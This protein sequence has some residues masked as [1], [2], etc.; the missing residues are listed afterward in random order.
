[1]TSR[2]DLPF[3]A[4]KQVRLSANHLVLSAVLA[5]AAAL[6]SHAHAGAQELEGL[7]AI[8]AEEVLD[9]WAMALGGRERLGGI[10]SLY[11]RARYE[12]TAGSGIVEEWSTAAGQR[13]QASDLTTGLE[14]TIFDVSRG[15][16]SSMN[17]IARELSPDERRAQLTAAYLA[18][19]SA[20]VSGRLAGKAE[21]AGQD[22]ARKNHLV[23]L[24]PEGGVPTLIAIDKETHLPSWNQQILTTAVLTIVFEGWREVSGIMVPARLRL[25]TDGGYA[26]TETL[27]EALANPTVED[28]LFERPPDRTGDLLFEGERRTATIPV[29]AIGGHLFL[30][31]RIGDS[32]P[33]WLTL[34]SGASGSILDADLA[35]SLG[36]QTTGRPQITGSGGAVEGA[37]AR[38]VTV[39][40]AGVRLADQTFLTMPLD[41]LS[42]PTGRRTA[43]ILGYN[44]FSRLTVEIDY[45]A[46]EIRLHDPSTFVYEG[47]GESLPLTIHDDQPYIRAR[48]GL[49]ERGE[50]EGEFVVDT[51]SASTLMIA[52]DFARSHRLL[53]SVG[54]TLVAS[55]R[56]V[57]GDISLTVGRLAA[58]KIGPFTLTQPVV[59]F[60]AGVITARGKAGNIGAGALRR[61]LVVFDY[62]RQ[63]LI[64]EP[65]SVYDEPDEY[66]M[67]GLSLMA[68]GTELDV[69]RVERVREGAPGEEA[70]VR[71]EDVLRSV[72]SRPAREIGLSGI[73]AM[74]RRQ[75]E[76]EIVIERDGRTLQLQLR[77]RRLV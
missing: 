59:L 15:G 64:L 69:I 31:G 3:L 61:F 35:A 65:A 4:A 21:Y 11:T 8:T 1:M 58:L 77:T 76:F 50:Q 14:L 42:G 41:F 16:W 6:P 24:L 49:G 36:L 27:L 63:R 9:D 29:E 56:G 68:A 72:S 34:D 25:T 66:D 39:H 38:G 28:G 12:G 13:R 26:A 52:E 46:Q 30:R 45:R 43:A 18:S 75:G 57:G 53:E 20:L 37:Y 48:L 70:G 2:P 55:G 60:P 32:D 7:A 33:V 19:F 23:R 22:D 17:G 51:G 71:P 47:S 54:R 44:L 73:R 10:R 74:F 62:P 67:S 40:L 5:T